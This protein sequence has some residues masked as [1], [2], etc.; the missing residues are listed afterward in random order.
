MDAAVE[1]DTNKGIKNAKSIKDDVVKFFKDTY[2]ETR[3]K[4]ISSQLVAASRNSSSLHG[5]GK[6]GKSK[7]TEDLTGVRLSN[8]T[9]YFQSFESFPKREES[10]ESRAT[11]TEESQLPTPPPTPT[12]AEEP[13]R[14]SSIVVNASTRPTPP[15]LPTGKLSQLSYKLSLQI[16]NSS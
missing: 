8:S 16:A 10:E 15:K 5:I 1:A 2:Q 9:F 12:P 4:H 3:I 6:L 14:K 7:A 11:L 13:V